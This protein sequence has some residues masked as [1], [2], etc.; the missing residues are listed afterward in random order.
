[1]HYVNLGRYDAPRLVTGRLDASESTQA[2]PPLFL[3]AVDRLVPLGPPDVSD[4]RRLR[5]LPALASLL[6]LPACLWLALETARRVR[7]PRWALIALPLAGMAVGT[8]MLIQSSRM[9]QYG[10]EMLSGALLPA[11]W[12]SR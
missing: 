8:N 4:E 1:A 5:L 9:K 11:V 2:A 10:P 7:L 6:A 3:L 12:L